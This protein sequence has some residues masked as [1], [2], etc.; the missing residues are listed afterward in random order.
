MNSKKKTLPKFHFFKR[1]KLTSFFHNLCEAPSCTTRY[2]Q[3]F[4]WQPVLW[5]FGCCGSMESE[6]AGGRSPT[7]MQRL[8]DLGPLPPSQAFTKVL[9][10]KWSSQDLNWHLYEMLVLHSLLCCDACRSFKYFNV[11]SYTPPITMIDH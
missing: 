7:G 10:G 3:S 11:M 8:K 2:N 9:S 4:G 1:A 5:P 6:A